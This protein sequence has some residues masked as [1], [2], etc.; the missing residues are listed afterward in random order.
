M[1]VRIPALLI[2]FNLASVA[3]PVPIFLGYSGCV[4]IPVFSFKLGGAAIPN[5]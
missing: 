4:A 5:S 3:I 1:S 2:N